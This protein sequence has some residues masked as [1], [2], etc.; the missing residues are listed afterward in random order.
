MTY[1]TEQGLTDYAAERGI[2]LTG[3]ASALL[4]LAHDYIEAQSYKGSAVSADARWPRTGVYL[5]G[6][7]LASD[8]VP[9][10]IV[11]AEYEAALAVD[12][13]NDPL[14][15]LTSGVKREKAGPVEIEYTD[16]GTSVAIN[17]RLDALL[18]PFLASGAGGATFTVT[19]A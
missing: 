2:T 4:A 8:S 10:Q 5:G 12:T 14:G 6:F 3:T 13:G 18:R 7:L 16:S 19:R 11:N 15:A 17:R 9:A 1:G